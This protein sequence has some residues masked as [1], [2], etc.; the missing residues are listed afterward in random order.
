MPLKSAT[1]GACEE[2]LQE[3]MRQIDRMVAQKKESWERQLQQLQ[4]RLS[5]R[6]NEHVIQ[7]ALLE[8]KKREVLQGLFP[9][10]A[11]RHYWVLF[12]YI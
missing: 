10:L 6:D 1:F 4:T 5:A 3:L 9:S 2:E 12:C 11:T 7:K 8:Q